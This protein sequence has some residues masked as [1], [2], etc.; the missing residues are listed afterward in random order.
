M[1]G[2][3]A[4]R[5]L[6]AYRFEDGNS[7]RRALDR[8]RACTH[9]IEKHERAALDG[10]KHLHDM[11][12]VRGEGGKRLL[13]ALL[14][15]DIREDIIE[16]A[17]ERAISGRNVKTR[18]G[19]DRE[20]TDGFERNG[21]TARIGTRDDQRIKLF[22][23]RNRDR[24][25][26][27]C[28]NERMA[29]FQKEKLLCR[30]NFGRDGVHLKGKLTLAEN[31]GKQCQIA[32]VFEDHTASICHVS[33]KLREDTLDLVRFLALKKAQ[34]IIGFHD[35]KRLHKKRGTRSGCI[36]NETLDLVFIFLLNGDY[37]SAVTHGDD[38]LLQEFGVC[39]ARDEF[40][41]R[42]TDAVVFNFHA[43]ANVVKLF[44]RHIRDGFLIFDAS[45]DLFFQIFIGREALKVFIEDRLG[46][47][48]GIAVFR[49]GAGGRKRASHGKELS[50]AQH[51]ALISA[52]HGSGDIRDAVKGRHTL[53]DLH[54]LCRLR[55]RQHTAHGLDRAG[56]SHGIRQRFCALG[57]ANGGEHLA[58]LIKFER[59]DRSVKFLFLYRFHWYLL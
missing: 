39:A 52:L 55:F 42:F 15:A 12:H 41:E 37:V 47:V 57:G 13:N 29:R 11:H 49:N 21:L 32:I 17:H 16:N 18:L 36:V 3:G 35:G 48:V 40:L 34:F 25:D 5:I 53:G 24:Y 43:A 8:V 45:C 33:G 30:R 14:I 58:D 20:K 27:V 10:S 2:S 28:G 54:I 46:G 4:E 44:A 19:H 56:R 51:S 1:C 31:E 50:D 23:K 59:Y 26:A 6:F 9:F 7:K 38:L 22:A